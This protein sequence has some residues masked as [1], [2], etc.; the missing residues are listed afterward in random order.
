MEH[1]EGPN[2]LENLFRLNRTSTDTMCAMSLLKKKKS[3]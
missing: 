3:E 1:K 2:D